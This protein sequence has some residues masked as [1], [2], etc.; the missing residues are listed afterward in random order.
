VQPIDKG[1]REVR[2]MQT[3]ARLCRSKKASLVMGN[4]AVPG[5]GRLIRRGRG[6]MPM[7]LVSGNATRSEAPQRIPISTYV[8]GCSIW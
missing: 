2:R 7:H 1:E 4:I 5:R 3:S 8:A 6:S